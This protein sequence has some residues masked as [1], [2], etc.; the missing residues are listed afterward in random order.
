MNRSSLVKERTPNDIIFTV[1]MILVW[2]NSILLRFIRVIIQ[3]IPFIWQH[4]DLILS[5]VF[6]I[7]LVLSLRVI[8]WYVYIKDLLYFLALYVV[9]Y[10]H[11]LLYPL[12]EP[13]F[14]IN[15]ELTITKCFPMF[16][17]GLCAYRI[18][19]E[20]TI[21]ILYQISVVSV[22]A[23]VI[24]ATVFSRIDAATLRDGDMHAAYTVLPHICLTFMGMLRK[25]NLWNISALTVGTVFLLFLGNRG[26]LLCLGICVIVSIL[27][28]GRLKRPWLFLL[29]SALVMV[30][31]FLFGLL[32]FL[33]D[34]AE[35]HGFS[36]RIFEKLESGEIASSSGRDQIQEKV[37]EAV[38][39]DPITG[40]G[41]FSDRRVAGGLYAHNIIPE[42]LLHHGIAVGT[43]LLGLL[44]Y[45]L[46]GAYGYLRRENHLAKDLYAAL[47]FSAV[48]KLFLSSSYLREPYFYFALGFAYAAMS[49]YRKRKQQERNAKERTGLVRYR[50]IRS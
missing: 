21:R 20:S 34:L 35:K 39:R 18:N 6:I 43:L 17:I 46:V 10:L 14:Q 1:F 25:P 13:Y 15:S 27:F 7:T 23:F 49:E 40:M 37:W 32:D 31:L 36:L 11:L 16:L 50:R 30:I 33:Y 5:L 47:L 45:V 28:S 19:R 42:I 44:S 24:Y 22:F 26:S 2:M 38:K 41:L 8:L 48:F 4:A 12:N 9:F 29:L 3:M